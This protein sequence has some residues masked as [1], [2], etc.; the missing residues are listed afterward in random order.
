MAPK[1]EPHHLLSV[2]L[3]DFHQHDIVT[4]YES[5]EVTK[6]DQYTVSDTLFVP[7]KSMRRG[8]EFSGIFSSLLSPDNQQH[9]LP[10]NLSSDAIVVSDYDGTMRVS[11]RTSCIVDAAK[12]SL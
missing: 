6:N 9:R 12:M 4:C 10:I 3:T 2:N 5:F 7:G 11:I 8:F 1:R